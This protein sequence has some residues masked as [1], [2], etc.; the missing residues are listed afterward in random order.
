M[1][2][3][4]TGKPPAFLRIATYNIHGFIGRDRSYDP[5]RIARVIR[6]LAA[7]VIAL[8]EVQARRYTGE[9]L[10][11]LLGAETGY[12]ALGGPTLLRDRGHYGNALLCRGKVDFH[13]PVDLTYRKR[14]P[15]GAINCRLSYG[16]RSLQVVATHLGLAPRERR[17]QV[18]HLIDHI[19]ER[20]RDLTVLV[21]DLNEWLLWGRPVRWLHRFFSR[22][23][24]LRT[25]PT[26]LPLFALDRIWVH[27]AQSLVDLEVHR[28]EA[29]RAASDH[30]PLIATVRLD[31]VMGRKR[32][33]PR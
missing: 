17:H 8:Q 31:G 9:E 14:E 13:E 22:T 26:T 25:F 28:S 6:E 3:N 24:A 12:T 1:A 20:D 29:A 4:G 30:F 16:G 10:L 2:D 7:D 11:G 5:R 27:P 23:P 32:T 15:R 18:L 21:G 19:L 33:I